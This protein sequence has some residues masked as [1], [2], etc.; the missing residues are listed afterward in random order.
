MVAPGQ[1]KGIEASMISGMIKAAVGLGFVRLSKVVVGV[2]LQ[3]RL[4][5]LISRLP[6]GTW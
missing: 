3:S 2:S 4:G 6:D 5:I 1:G